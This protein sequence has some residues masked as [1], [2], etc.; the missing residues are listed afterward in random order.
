ML[1]RFVQIVDCAPVLG[2]EQSDVE[3]VCADC[4]PVLGREQS[5][6]ESD[7]ADCAE[8]RQDPGKHN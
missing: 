7:C 5:D 6:V 8:D 3:S 2:W 1:N 4:A